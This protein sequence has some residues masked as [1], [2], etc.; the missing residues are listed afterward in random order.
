[1]LLFIEIMLTEIV[2]TSHLSYFAHT[3]TLTLL[4]FLQKYK[5]MQFNVNKQ[6]LHK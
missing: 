3:L 6:S 5:D 2:K 1:M 4:L